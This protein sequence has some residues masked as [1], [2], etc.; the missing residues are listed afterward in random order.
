MNKKGNIE[1]KK[2]SKGE[3]GAI[4]TS[5]VTNVSAVPGA[6]LSAALDNLAGGSVVLPLTTKGDMLTRTGAAMVRFPVGADGRVLAADSASATGLNWALQDLGSSNILYVDGARTD[7]YVEDGTSVRPFRTI[8]AATAVAARGKVI[9]LAPSTYQES[10]TMIDGVPIIGEVDAQT[11]IISNQDTITMSGGS[12]GFKLSNIA[13]ITTGVGKYA[14][15]ATGIGSGGVTFENMQIAAT[16]MAT[17]AALFRNFAYDSSL[18]LFHC[19]FYGGTVV[20]GVMNAL[21]ETCLMDNNSKSVDTLTIKN[22]GS[23]PNGATDIMFLM[24]AISASDITQKA[25]YVQGGN[26]PGFMPNATFLNSKVFG[27]CEVGDMG[28][29]AAAQTIFSE[30]LTVGAGSLYLEGFNVYVGALNIDPA[31]NHVYLGN[32]GAVGNDS[33]VS[34]AT[35]KDALNSI[36]GLID[37]TSTIIAENSGCYLDPA[38]VYRT[39][40]CDSGTAQNFTLPVGAS[41]LVGIEYSFFKIGSGR[42]TITAGAGGDFIQDSSAGGTVYCDDAKLAS[43]KLKLVAEHLWMIVPMTNSWTTT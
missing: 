31:A 11:Y 29:M 42:L 8:A 17:N 13:V 27:V 1:L 22:Y 10:V 41:Q 7:S 16:D 18:N 32:A 30:S 35:I 40:T 34:G 24:G 23:G 3:A 26:Q 4:D 43:I 2:P 19:S 21:V 20:D 6:D 28:S 36:A 15:K 5:E 33:D 14:V 38:E 39:F 9:K 37:G 12:W 25:I